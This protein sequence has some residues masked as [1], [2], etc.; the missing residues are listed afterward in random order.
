MKIRILHTRPF[1]G[2]TRREGKVLE[3]GTDVTAY[4]ARLMV[5]TGMAE[6]VKSAPA[7]AADK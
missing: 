7:K 4:D 2:R 6:A 3:V 5:E 1:A